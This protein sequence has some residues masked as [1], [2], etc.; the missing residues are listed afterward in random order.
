MLSQERIELEKLLLQGNNFMKNVL[1]IAYYFP[2]IG[3]GG[4]QRSINFVKYLPDLGYFPIVL[5]CSNP[6]EERWTPKDNTLRK[7][8]KN[9]CMVFR[10]S[11]PPPPPD[12]K[13]MQRIKKLSFLQ[14]S[15][16][17]WWIKYAIE[18][19]DEIIKENK[20]DVVYA[21]MSPFQSSYVADYLS[22]KY[23]IP[24]VA[25]LRD[26]W[27]LDEMV[28]Y[29]SS[30]H[31]K[32]D[33][34]RMRTILFGA[35][36]IIMNTPEAAKSLNIH[37]SEFNN[38]YVSAITNGYDA[39]DFN[40]NVE[41]RIN[42]KFRIVHSGSLYSETGKQLNKYRSLYNILGGANTNVNILGRSLIY[43]LESLE[44]WAEE[45]PEILNEIEV[46]LIG[47][48]GANETA[49]LEGKR[50]RNIFNFT[51]Y[52]PHDKIRKLAVSPYA[53]HR[54]WP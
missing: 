24:W 1:F 22:K 23:D 7:Y 27:A 28:L 39:I 36:A 15:F 41:N 38:K 44:K 54:G 16:S 33:L 40:C 4:I 11:T 50:C 19:G 8:I 47:K 45:S 12:T 13:I 20:I 42:K 26:P 21:S 18:L 10:I 51:G 35:S 3:G 37:F 31:K 32:Y 30:L 2:P 9:N 49:M 34:H 5:T 46:M 25:D 14:D 43:L 52:I 29:P 17:K 6:A 48:S 53:W